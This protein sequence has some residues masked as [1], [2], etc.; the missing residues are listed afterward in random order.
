MKNRTV[1]CRCGFGNKMLNE[2]INLKLKNLAIVKAENMKIK[3]IEYFKYNK[4]NF[5]QYKNFNTFISLLEKG[6]INITFMI[7]IYKSGKRFGQTHDRG[8]AFTIKEKDIDL[9]YDKYII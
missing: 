3:G 5:Y 6:K 9:L 4:I 7:G 1:S 8:T 2:R